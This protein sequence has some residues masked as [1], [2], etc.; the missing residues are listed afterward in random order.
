MIYS[1]IKNLVVYLILSNVLNHMI[2]GSNYK[3]YIGFFSGLIIV[4]ILLEPL[5]FILGDSERI[6][7][8]INSN[9]NYLLGDV[10][11]GTKDEIMAA[12]PGYMHMS[13]EEALVK[14]LRDDLGMPDDSIHFVEVLTDEQCS[15]TACRVGVSGDIDEEELTMKISYFYNM[16]INNIYILRR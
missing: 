3:K 9:I 4:V 6:T 10:Y 5:S 7:K 2:P 11:E 14:Y 16:D 1:W 8:T 13:L 12:G 15:V